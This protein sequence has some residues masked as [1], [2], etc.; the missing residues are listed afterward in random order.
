M[1]TYFEDLAWYDYLICLVY[2]GIFSYMLYKIG[3]VFLN[4]HK[5]TLFILVAAFQVYFFL[6]MA[7]SFWNILPYNPESSW[8]SLI[9]SS[10]EYPQDAQVNL[11]VLYYLSLFFSIIC[12]NTPIIYIFISAIV[13]L[14]GAMIMMQAWKMLFPTFTVK[15]ENTAAWL[16]LFFPAPLLLITAPLQTGF[17]ILGFGFL[18]RGWAKYLTKG[19]VVN[20]ITGAIVM[21]A[22]QFESIY[23]VIPMVL[24]TI[25]YRQPFSTWLKAGITI[26]VLIAGWF[27]AGAVLPDGP[28]SPAMLAEMRNTS[29]AQAD[30]YGYGNVYWTSYGAMI[31]DYPFIILQF[32]VAP[33]PVFMQFDLASAPVAT[34]DA[35]FTALVFILAVIAFV[36]NGRSKIAVLLFMVFFM[37]FLG[38]AEDNWMHAIAN[39]MPFVIMCIFL[40]AGLISGAD[41]KTTTA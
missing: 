22:M 40:T 21:M 17:I 7:D 32:I 5:R 16:L 31:K 33:L 19:T 36:K 3:E 6:T 26:V 29:I 13:Y 8:F 12:L 15:A 41:K 4:M 11:M 34:A 38:G 1:K 9:V 39:R 2:N 20:L 30:V 27:I 24:G 37:F 10:G 35:I 25:L 14:T 18:L 23:W 28:L